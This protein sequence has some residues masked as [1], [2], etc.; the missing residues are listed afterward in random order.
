MKFIPIPLHRKGEAAVM[1]EEIAS[2]LKINY[3]FIYKV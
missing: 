2:Y 1:P 3:Y